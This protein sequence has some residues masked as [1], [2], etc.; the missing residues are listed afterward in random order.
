MISTTTD[1]ISAASSYTPDNLDASR[2][3]DQGPSVTLEKSTKIDTSQNE[4]STALEW[5]GPNDQENP[6]NW[7]V[8]NKV[9]HTAIP[10]IYTFAL[11]VLLFVNNI[12]RKVLKF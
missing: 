11:Y 8:G 5:D 6:Q 9:F 2:A 12:H 3:K 10:A 4:N 1:E 7:S